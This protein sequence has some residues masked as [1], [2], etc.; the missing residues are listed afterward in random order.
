[1][2]QF[3]IA[4]IA[5]AVPDRAVS[6]LQPDVVSYR[7]RG[8]LQIHVGIVRVETVQ[9]R[10]EPANRQT[11]CH[12][13]AQ[14]FFRLLVDHLVQRI[15]QTIKCI[16]DAVSESFAHRSKLDFATRLLKQLYAKPDL[17]MLDL[18]AH[19]AWRDVQ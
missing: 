2:I 17:K 7:N 10:N 12:F 19:G 18:L 9:A 1:M 11:G 14:P 6:P 5:H 8:N 3:D 13:Q 15:V 4:P 16:R